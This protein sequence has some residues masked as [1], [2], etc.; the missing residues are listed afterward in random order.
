MMSWLNIFF[1]L[2]AYAGIAFM[3]LRFIQFVAECDRDIE[4]MQKP[5]EKK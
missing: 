3:L 2:A 5:K 4:V 1:A